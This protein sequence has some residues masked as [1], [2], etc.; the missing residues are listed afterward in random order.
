MLL[1]IRR[2]ALTNMKLNIRL[3]YVKK[4]YDYLLRRLRV[5]LEGC[6]PPS[7]FETPNFA[8]LRYKKYINYPPKTFLKKTLLYSFQNKKL[9]RP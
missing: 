3:D 6:L 5:G 2:N 8:H 7:N 4:T 9:G 1:S